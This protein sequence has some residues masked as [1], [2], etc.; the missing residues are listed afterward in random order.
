MQMTNLGY[1]DQHGHNSP[2]HDY[3]LPLTPDNVSITTFYTWNK[4]VIK[5]IQDKDIRVFSG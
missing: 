4:K 3:D 1:D 5:V 2:Q